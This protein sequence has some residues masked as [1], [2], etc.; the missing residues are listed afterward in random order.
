M[1]IFIL[2]Q[3]KPSKEIQKYSKRDN[4]TEISL[5]KAKKIGFFTLLGNET[6]IM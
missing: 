4:K 2:I 1:Y 6:Q 3:I 5:R